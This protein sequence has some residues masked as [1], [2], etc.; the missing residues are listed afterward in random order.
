M[1]R[2]WTATA[3][4]SAGLLVLSTLFY[5]YIAF[6]SYVLEHTGSNAH[7]GA[8]S[9]V[10]A[11]LMRVAGPFDLVV[12]ALAVLNT[13]FFFYW[14]FLSVGLAR[15]IEPAS[16]RYPPWTALLGFVVPIVNLW[17]PIYTL[18]D[19]D[20][21]AARQEARSTARFPLLA[22]AMM[23]CCVVALTASNRTS[24]A[25]NAGVADF[26]AGQSLMQL[27]SAGA[28][29]N[30]LLLMLVQVF[31]HR[32]KPG[33]DIALAKLAAAEAASQPASWP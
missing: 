8:D 5:L 17:M 3:L 24:Q 6:V 11:V 25:S 18:V 7:T 27:A 28:I 2:A 19:L 30:I 16:V 1:H 33:Q 14:L 15:A 21:F 29:A 26:A 13:A 4:V 12:A 31:M 10:F 20:D 23:L 9:P 32:T 22:S